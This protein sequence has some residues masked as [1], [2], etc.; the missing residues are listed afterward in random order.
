MGIKGQ[1]GKQERKG[2]WQQTS[3]L[4]STHTAHAWKGRRA[5]SNAALKSCVWQTGNTTCAFRNPQ[6]HSHVD[7]CNTH[8]NYLFLIIFIFAKLLNHLSHVIKKKHNEKKKKTQTKSLGFWAIKNNL[9]ILL[10]WKKKRS[11][12]PW[13][14]NNFFL[15]KGNLF[16]SPC[17]KSEMINFIPIN[18]I[19][20]KEPHLYCGGH[21][22]Y[23]SIAIHNAMSLTP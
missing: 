3:S 1:R 6:R 9:V 4:L 5:L 17:Q 8:V 10:F 23:Y 11:S 18:L 15:F 22:H 19:I 20:S 13:M 21:K 2:W 16:F 14:P 7:V 12:N